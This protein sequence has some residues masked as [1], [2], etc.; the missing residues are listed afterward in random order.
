MSDLSST[1]SLSSLKLTQSLNGIPGGFD[2]SV[3][4]F[5]R[6]LE[7]IGIYMPTPHIEA[8]QF[9]TKNLKVTGIWDKMYVIYPFCGG[10]SQSHSLNLKDPRALPAAYQITWSGGVTH[11]LLGANFNGVNAFGESNYILNLYNR[12]YNVSL[13]VYFTGVNLYNDITDRYII[14]SSVTGRNFGIYQQRGTISD[15]NPITILGGI[16]YGGFNGSFDN[17]TSVLNRYGMICATRPLQSQLPVGRNQTRIHNN[18]T[19]L[20]PELVSGTVSVTTSASSQSIKI[21]CASGTG[22][23][24]GRYFQGILQFTYWGEHLD[25]IEM[26]E[27]AKIVE[28]YQRIMGRSP[29]NGTDN[30]MVNYTPIL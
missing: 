23:A 16:I 2:E 20:R 1:Y 12:A 10:T 26:A 29:M 5:I 28:T 25:T 15:N 8:L 6:T 11:S 4:S 18:G 3:I 13:G 22:N 17:R 9:L 19:E 21:G 24:P 30:Y 27:L 14:G 7:N